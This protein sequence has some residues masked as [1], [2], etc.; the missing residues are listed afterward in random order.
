[1][2]WLRAYRARCTYASQR[3]SALWLAFALIAQAAGAQDSTLIS[4]LK[5]QPKRDPRP[6]VRVAFTASGGISAGAYQAGVTWA[7]VQ[8]MKK[9]N[10]DASWAKKVGAPKFQLVATAGAS[11]G[12]LNALSIAVAWTDP[13]QTPDPEQSLFWNTWIPTG[14]EELRPDPAKATDLEGDQAVFSRQFVE[15]TLYPR[16][17]AS[18]Q[19]ANLLPCRIP[20]GITLTSVRTSA[21]TVLDAID[22]QVQR[23]VLATVLNTT[24][25]SDER[26]EQPD[27]AFAS[28]KSVG[29]IVVPAVSGAMYGAKTL[30]PFVAA[31]SAFPVAFAPVTLNFRYAD[32]LLPDRTCPLQSP[33]ICLGPRTDLFADGG[34]FDSNPIALALDLTTNYWSAPKTE[35]AAKAE[36]LNSSKQT[37]G[38]DDA[39]VTII[40]TNPGLLR[41]PDPLVEK[42]PV[43]TGL[44]AAFTYFKSA[45]PAARQ[46]ELFS[47][48]RRQKD[49]EAK[50][51]G[52][53]QQVQSVRSFGQIRIV[54][55]SYRSVGCVT[56]VPTFRSGTIYGEFL[57]N[58]AAFLGRP[59][60]EV[61]FYSGV[62]DGT[63]TF[64]ESFTCTI[65]R[66]EDTQSAERRWIAQRSECLRGRLIN[67]FGG[68]LP[69]G[70]V[71]RR[72]L[73]PLLRAEFGD[74]AILVD[75]DPADM[76]ERDRARLSIL[77]PIAD[78]TVK[79][80]RGA[81]RTCTQR[82]LVQNL[83]CQDGLDSLLAVLKQ[84]AL[85]ASIRGAA[86]R[87]SE[88]DS[89]GAGA[90]FVDH[91]FAELAADPVR[92]VDSI[93]RVILK[94]LGTVEARERQNGRPDHSRVTSIASLLFESTAEVRRRGLHWYPSSSALGS[95][96]VAKRFL[97]FVIPYTLGIGVNRSGF[98]SSWRPTYYFSNSLGIILP[99]GVNWALTK[100]SASRSRILEAHVSTGLLWRWPSLLV[101]S[102]DFSAGVVAPLMTVR[103]GIG[104][105]MPSIA[106]SGN[107][108]VGR[109]AGID[110]TYDFGA[111][112]AAGR[113]RLGWRGYAYR[114]SAVRAPGVATVSLTDTPSLLRFLLGAR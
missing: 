99:F 110:G 42:R 53:K 65:Q 60:R 33:G 43:P 91:V 11:A 113:V 9:S 7:L 106:A 40:F 112:F 5:C 89:V 63:R 3:H 74:A 93:A 22:V 31:S 88:A 4:G 32:E 41:R 79:H 30:L 77:G 69:I 13:Q 83:L 55:P 114:T 16:V 10:D 37:I 80:R 52:C 46:Y 64:F 8:L 82:D 71:G 2:S 1:M 97:P 111:T 39:G 14:L 87:C 61:D 29:G 27:T 103:E 75:S 108:A 90:C 57:G 45:V 86:A 51:A 72:V 84:P 94:Q 92:T 62:F 107:Q 58:F 67:V 20:I 15:R 73:A 49:T 85:L 28:N 21:R 56:I 18:V 109:A 76:T 96:G 38:A 78:A 70:N 24:G 68:G 35:S 54:F 17:V 47:F 36:R 6:Q 12:N 98:M 104:E 48:D 34:L 101:T 44:G 81:G 25:Q 19:S 105:L 102:L 100:R 59:Y 50:G 23:F 95:A 26:F 66:T